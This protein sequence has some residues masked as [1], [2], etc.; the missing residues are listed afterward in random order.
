MSRVNL[1]TSTVFW[2][3]ICVFRAGSDRFPAGQHRIH[4][5]LRRRS[6]E[7]LFHARNVPAEVKPKK[8]M[9]ITDG[10][11]LTLGD[12]TLTFYVTPGH[13]PGMVSML[14]P[15]KDG[16]QRHLGGL[17][18]GLG[19]GNDRDGVKYF[20]NKREMLNA[21]STSAKRWQDI[22]T[23][24]GVDVLVTNHTRLDKGLE[25]MAAV[26]TRKPGEPHPFVGKDAVQR[27]MTVINNCAEAQLAWTNSSN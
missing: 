18:G 20:A 25:K 10:Q 2:E 11:K 1:Q 14:I 5:I 24:A 26:K 27:F 17:W 13:T 8:D 23:K 9:V 19:Y 7:A 6:Y 12:T 22:E 21:Y 15:L 16:S 3:G 4:S